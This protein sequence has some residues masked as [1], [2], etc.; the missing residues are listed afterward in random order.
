MTKAQKE[1]LSKFQ[2]LPRRWRRNVV[3]NVKAGVKTF[4][5][6]KVHHKWW[7]GNNP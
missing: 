3:A 4:G 2:A 6:F 7:E 1:L 5:G